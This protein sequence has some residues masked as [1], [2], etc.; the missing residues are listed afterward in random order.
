MVC[1]SGALDIG[2]TARAQAKAGLFATVQTLRG[3][4]PQTEC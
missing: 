4:S 2:D 1:H 3:Q